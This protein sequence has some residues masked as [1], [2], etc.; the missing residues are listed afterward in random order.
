M[1]KSKREMTSV[2]PIT[3]YYIL[4]NPKMITLRET[5]TGSAEINWHSPYNLIFNTY[6][7]KY[8]FFLS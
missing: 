4:N 8:K 1:Q 5:Q 7:F 6:N 2:S 3:W